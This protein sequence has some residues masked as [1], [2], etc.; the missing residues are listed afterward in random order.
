MFGRQKERMKNVNGA[1]RNLNHNIFIYNIRVLEYLNGIEVPLRTVLC[2]R[3]VTWIGPLWT[4]KK[5]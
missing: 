3:S 5:V 4:N 1:F 2:T